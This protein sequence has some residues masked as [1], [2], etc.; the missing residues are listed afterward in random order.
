MK[1]SLRFS[2][3]MCCNVLEPTTRNT[4]VW[5]CLLHRRA[6]PHCSQAYWCW[7]THPC[8]YSSSLI[9]MKTGPWVWF[10]VSSQSFISTCFISTHNTIFSYIFKVA[11]CIVNFFLSKLKGH[12]ICYDATR[13]SYIVTLAVF[14]CIA[15]FS[16]GTKQKALFHQFLDAITLQKHKNQL[17]DDLFNWKHSRELNSEI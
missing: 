7:K 6:S 16:T 12:E 8:P 11:C 15:P 14:D 3:K 4:G 2:I 13:V 1:L 9:C 17:P 10:S 5:G